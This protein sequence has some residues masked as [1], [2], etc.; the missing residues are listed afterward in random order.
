MKILRR[1]KQMSGT[2]KVTFSITTVLSIVV[3]ML[4][5]AGLSGIVE[6]RVSNFISQPIMGTV[7]LLVGVTKYKNEKALALFMFSVSAFVL[8]MFAFVVAS[9]Y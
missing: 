8:I 4:S 9:Y 3:L 6:T 1:Y 7:F 2:E 5:I